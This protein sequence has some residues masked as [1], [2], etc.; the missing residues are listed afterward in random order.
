MSRMARALSLSP[1][2]DPSIACFLSRTTSHV[3]PSEIHDA[4]SVQFRLNRLRGS[5]ARR[6]LNLP[7][8]IRPLTNAWSGRESSGGAP[9]APGLLCAHSARSES[10]DGRSSSTLDAMN[11]Q[12][13]SPFPG[14]CGWRLREFLR[15]SW[16]WGGQFLLRTGYFNPTPWIS[17]PCGWVAERWLCLSA[18]HPR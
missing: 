10:A 5:H 8:L 4:Y 1:L 16:R 15:R 3:S 18:H 11:A 7:S 17:T 14:S 6:Q 13:G 9:C 2:T 12:G